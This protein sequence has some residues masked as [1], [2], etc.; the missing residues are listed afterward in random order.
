MRCYEVVLITSPDIADDG[1]KD[2]LEKV[3]GVL[4]KKRKKAEKGELLNVKNWGVRRLS[5]PI[6]KVEKGRY[7]LLTLKC[8]P[9]SLAEVERNLRLADDVLRYQT[10]RLNEEPVFEEPKEVKVEEKAE[11]VKVAEP[12]AADESSNVAEAQ[13]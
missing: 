12:A 13:Q 8:L 5:A 1:H 3:E 6:K 11:D 9:D 7:D 2:L 10:I 4:K